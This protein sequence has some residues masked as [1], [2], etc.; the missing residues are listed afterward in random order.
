MAGN[1]WING[2]LEA[3]LDT[4]AGGVEDNKAVNLNDHGSHFNPTKYFV[5]E[6]VTGVDETDLHR[7]WLKVVATRNTRER[8]TRLENMC[9]RI[10]HLARKKKQ[11]EGEDSQRLANR[12]SEREQGRRDATEDMSEDLSEGEKGDVMGEMVQ[13]ET[14]R[15]KLQRNFSDL[16]VW[17]D[18]DK[19]KRLY[20]VLI[21]LH[22]LVRGD[23]ME[24]GRDSDTGGQVKYVV[25]LSRA[26][27]MMP[28]VY[29][30]DLF[31]RQI[32][33]PEVDWSYGEPTEMLTSG[34]YG[35][36]DGRDVGESS[37]AYIIRIPCGP[38][39]KYLRKESL[40]P[41]VQEFVDGALAHILN[42]SKVLGEQIGGGQPVWPYV[43]HG[44]YADAGDSA[45]LLSGALNVP[46]VLTGHSLGRNKLEQLLKQGRQS[47]EDI[48]ATYKIMR[49]IEAEEL[50]LDAAE[51]V[52][53]STKQEIEEQWGLYDGF[54]VKLEKVLRARARRGVNCH[55]RYMPR[56]VVIP[57]GM[58]FSSVIQEQ[59]PSETDGE[60]A[61]LI[62]TD[63]TSPKAIPPIWS[64]VMRFLT[65][66][67]KPMILA[68][69]RPD[70]K[71][72]ITTLLKAF[73]ECRPLRDLANLTLIMGNR[74]DID[75]MS[76]GNASVLTTVL[77]M[78]DK[79]DLYGLVAY[80][81][82]HKQADVPDI[83]RLAGKTRGVFINPALVEPFGLTLIEAAAHGLPM[84]A[85]KNGGPVDIHR[86]LNNGLLVD[87]HDEKAI[88]D[89]L[90]KLVAEKNLWH[91]CRWNGWKNIHLFSWPEHCRTYLSRVA[92]C[93]MR[94]P[95]WKTDTPVDDT[96]VEE[97]MG[98][99]LKDVHDMSLRLSVDGDKI[100]VN[101]SLE[102]DP[103]ELEKM[104]ALKG[105]KEV[106]DQVKR[107]LSRLKKPSAA[108]LGAEAGKK[109]GENTMNKYPV[110]WRRRKLFVIALDCYDDHGKPES[111]MLQVIQETFK[112]VRTDPSAARFSGFALSTAMPVSEILKLLES[113]KIQVTEFDALICSSGSEVYY[114]GTYQ[115]MDEE[116]RLCADP[117]YASHIDYR[118][119]CDGL[120]KTI[121]KLMSSSEG[122]DESII[123]EDKASCNS[124]CVSYFIKDSTKARKVDD[125]RQKLRM[126]GL[127]CH[128][129]YCRN[130]TRLQAI[131]LL[132]SR[133]QAIRYL[134]VRWG[135]NVANMYVVLGETGDTDYE[136]LVSGSHKTL[137]LKDLVKKGSEE[138]L[139]TLGSYQ[140]GDMVPEESPLVVCTNGGQTAEDI[141]NALKQVYKATVGL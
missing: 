22:G 118:W 95:Q 78:I 1:E 69:A 96:V 38:R 36:R 111:K 42:M 126:R 35:H 135:L 46:M 136:E 53:T 9:W 94:H 41:Y 10:W 48:N 122:K 7:T 23:N 13:S 104:V 37:G 106:S 45:A 84:V 67:H 4:G 120:K 141:S 139:R 26:L 130:S 98:D 31:T 65:N 99:S 137:I 83:Y 81:K 56:M 73:G 72:N 68:L 92:A 52:I 32:S 49:R 85:T 125:L 24:L 18:D 43:I 25:E 108:T 17:S 133:S 75:K 134:F 70:P 50:S 123:Q 8:S 97:S 27:S 6:V 115:C 20:I 34:S 110:L 58:D 105:D 60:L 2:Y 19:A 116:G 113:G 28:G 90:L 40:W 21:S 132:A 107:V 57:P 117:D 86:A 47:K 74:D 88:A 62:G 59:D 131:P 102:N 103:A 44:H 121:S 11:L 30:V 16:Q 3:I 66:P 77:K 127:R 12:R 140:R 5:E 101:G 54:D 93:R 82:H 138:L 91:E 63:G 80:P 109:Q 39:D 55:G 71:K 129:M 79:Y 100:S 29:R 128:L 114:P 89:A 124:H 51:L 76:S 33:S 64:E 119:G 14:P 15:R 61:A 87:P 112:A